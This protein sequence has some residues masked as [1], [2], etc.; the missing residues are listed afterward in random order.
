MDWTLLILLLIALGSIVQLWL[1]LN[2]QKRETVS[3]HFA[4]E[5]AQREL[6][7]LQAA[8]AQ[9]IHVTRLAALG[10][11]LVS[12]ARDVNVPL[13]LAQNNIAM[14][15]ELLDEYRNL[16]RRYDTAV[17]HCLQPV[18]LLFSADKA[19]LDKLVK[20][21]EEARRK[22][23]EARAD[24]ESSALPNSA[25]QLLADARASLAE[26]SQGVQSLKEFA[27]SDSDT[28]ALVDV[29]ERVGKA[30][31]LAQPRLS[32]RIE[33]VRQIGNLPKVRCAPGDLDQVFLNLITNAALAIESRGRLTI[34]GKAEG[35]RIE[36]S[37]ED[38]GNGIADNILPKI[39]E[40][41]FSTRPPG[42]GTGL[43]L[44]IA[45]KIVTGMGGAIRVKTTPK[46]GSTFTVS[47]PT[48]SAASAEGGDVR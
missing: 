20:Y 16:V 37:F 18:D 47:L 33:I 7:R 42:E 39:F 44:T 8:Q 6:D 3:A 41:F 13:G 23:F 19:S 4:V 34:S 11:M 22:L 9:T 5:E 46:Q 48:G 1:E 32:D 45:H 26:L 38:T 14:I 17:Q 31:A 10:Q 28:A 35:E 25:G 2:K 30:L 40:P 15:A 12:I 36:V 29:G 43:G 24:V 27:R 21:V